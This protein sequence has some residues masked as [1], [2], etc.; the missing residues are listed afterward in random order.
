MNSVNSHSVLSPIEAYDA[1]AASYRSYAES[2]ELYLRA[3]DDI[4]ISR[5][6]HA[7]S[8]LDVGAGDGLRAIQIGRAAGVSRL[9]LLEP[10]PGMRARCPEGAEVWPS[11]IEEIPDAA[12]SFEVITCLWNVLGHIQ[13]AQRRVYALA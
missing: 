9:V 12:P 13:G 7:N 5:V 6:R 10:S 11:A 2:R 3:I 8:L 4:V 1:F